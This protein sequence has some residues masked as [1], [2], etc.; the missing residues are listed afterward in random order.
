MPESSRHKR[1]NI[2]NPSILNA[3]FR[4]G[5]ELLIVKVVNDV[6]EHAVEIGCDEV[7][8]ESNDVE[9]KITYS[10]T[11]MRI[12]DVSLAGFYHDHLR[13][14]VAELDT[15]G[16]GDAGPGEEWN[17]GVLGNETA[18]RATVDE[19]GEIEIIVM[20]APTKFE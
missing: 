19:M 15:P 4:L 13:K 11:G 7:R 10:F 1:G 12:E 9:L 18:F 3:H 14:A 2:D 20:F 8:L 17:L 6:L 16:N 5:P